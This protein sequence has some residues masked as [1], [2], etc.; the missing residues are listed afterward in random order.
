MKGKS[1]EINDLNFG[2]SLKWNHVEKKG[3]SW[4]GPRPSRPSSSVYFGY[5]IPASDDFFPLDVVLMKN[6]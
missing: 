1:G 2:S 4:A 3:T 5:E 6:E